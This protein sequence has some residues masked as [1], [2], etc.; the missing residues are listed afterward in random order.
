M[1]EHFL[2][3]LYSYL[4]K[5]T[6]MYL[7]IYAEEQQVTKCWISIILSSCYTFLKTH[8]INSIQKFLL[9]TLASI[10]EN[11]YYKFIV[12][13]CQSNRWGKNCHYCT[14]WSGDFKIHVLVD[15]CM[16]I[17]KRN[18]FSKNEFN[19]STGW[20]WFHSSFWW[21]RR[22]IFY[23]HSFFKASHLHL[24]NSLK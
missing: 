2:D 24:Q 5:S 16:W 7:S 18:Y 23:Y 20:I 21:N 19:F 1:H 6:S 10:F 15:W 12:V 22:S 3:T 8:L 9:D 17:C 13:E 4:D 11:P 14:L